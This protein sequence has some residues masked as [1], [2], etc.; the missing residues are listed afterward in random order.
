MPTYARL[1]VTLVRG[2]GCRAWA[3]DGTPYLDLLGGLGALSLGHAH[4]RWVAAVSG[5]A[6]TIGLTTN[7]L[8]TVPQA[9]LADRPA[10]ITPV[11]EATVIFCNSGAE[12]NEALLKLVRKHGLAT[13][14]PVVVALEGSFHGRTI[15]TLAATGQPAKRA[16][17]EPLVDWIRFVPPGDLVALD[18]ALAHGDVGAVLLEPILGEGGVMPLGSTYLRAV[19]SRCDAAGALF[20][21]DEIQTGSGRTGRWLALEAADVRPDVV[22]LAKA[23][24][25]GLPIGAI[26]AR[27]DLAFGPGEH[28]STFGGGPVP[29]AAAMAVLDTI[30]A[31]DLLANVAAMGAL[32]RGE[33]ARLAPAGLLAEIRG[34]G[35]LCGFRLPGA[36]AAAVVQA[37]LARGVLASTAGPDVVRCTPPFTIGPD[38]IDEGAKALAAAF[39]D[40]G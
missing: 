40:A 14:R 26:V 18:A 15:A 20:A 34:D 35:L 3:D 38:E 24:G 5:A 22:A 23:L 33:V 28:G 1:P 9:A 17:F 4:P 19:R 6:A 7:L 11:D 30:E 10:A 39:E 27:A 29:C 21:A 31:D 37:L 32:L 13:G 2:E 25:G 12:A 36:N 8:T 16:P